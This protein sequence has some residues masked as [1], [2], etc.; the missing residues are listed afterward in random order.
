MTEPQPPRVEINWVQVSASA[1]AAVSSAVLLSTVGVAGTIIG[2]AIGS[3][4]ATAGS[5]IY[6]HFL[7]LSRSRVAAA[8]AAALDRL[9]HARSGASG[10]WAD[11]RRNP[12]PTVTFSAARVAA[13][14]DDA[15]R[16]LE[17]APDEARPSWREVLA[18][19][20][21]KR[22][23]AVAGGIF[24]VAMLVIVS[25]ELVTGRAVSTYTGGADSGTRSSIPGLGA[26]HGSGTPAKTPAP[27]TGTTSS[28]AA[29]SSTSTP[30]ETPTPSP[31]ETPSQAPTSA[32][33][34]VAPSSGAS[35]G[36]SSGPGSVP[37]AVPTPTQGATPAG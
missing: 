5:A 35:S 25:F 11:T 33:P 26:K 13:E 24:V 17:S 14:L 21:W 29:P 8:Q 23:A 28:P 37:S 3:V 30:S 10:V 19:L 16:E 12:S 34:T 36:V 27:T 18:D 15:E 20:R 9:T 32:P 4:F 6:S 1:L 2:A 7:G 22:I 31:S